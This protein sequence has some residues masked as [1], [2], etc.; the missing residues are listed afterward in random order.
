MNKKHITNIQNF[1]IQ[2]LPASQAVSNPNFLSPTWDNLANT[3]IGANFSGTFYPHNGSLEDFIG[4]V[5]GTWELV[6]ET[7]DNFFP[8]GAYINSFVRD[9]ELIFCDDSGNVCCFPDG[10]MLDIET[11]QSCQGRSETLDFTPNV[12]NSVDP[13]EYGYTFLISD[14]DAVHCRHQFEFNGTLGEDTSIICILSLKE[15]YLL[16]IH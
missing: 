10:G 9:I 16:S 1:D 13:A 2:F 3:Y 4:S 11:I 15:H 6:I 5:N 8:P 7:V 12:F 14:E